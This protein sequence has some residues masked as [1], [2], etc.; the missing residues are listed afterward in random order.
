MHMYVGHGIE[1]LEILKASINKNYMFVIALVKHYS[2]F[3]TY[4]YTCLENSLIQNVPSIVCVGCTS[5]K[6]VMH[7]DSVS[8]FY[9]LCR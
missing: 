8:F 3:P 2:T 6:L 7:N 9:C 1:C 5:Y 4:N